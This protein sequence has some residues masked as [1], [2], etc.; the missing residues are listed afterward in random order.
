MRFCHP[1]AGGN[2]P[3]QFGDFSKLG[4]NFSKL[5]GRDVTGLRPLQANSS[6]KN[7][8]LRAHAAG[9]LATSE[10]FPGYKAMILDFP[11]IS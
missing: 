1:K 2:E 10:F 7:T 3:P 5:K 4:G 11:G 9:F 8:K 6:K